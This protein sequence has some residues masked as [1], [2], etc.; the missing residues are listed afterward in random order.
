MKRLLMAVLMLAAALGVQAATFDGTEVPDN[1]QV[2]GVD[3]VLNGAGLRTKFVFDIYEG[4]LYLPQKANDTQAVLA[5]SG[6]DRILMHMIYAVSKSQFADAWND[7]F[8]DNN[9]KMSDSLKANVTQFIG[10]FG[11]SKK[12]DIV[13]IDYVPGTGTQVSWNGTLSGTIPGEE[14]HQAFLRVFFGSN[15]PTSRL[16]K[17]MLGK[18]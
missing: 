11:D 9:D 6:P 14:F 16:Q 7:G 8:G 2:G 4:A 15:P 13:T 5:H 17:G 18:S 3:L 1:A 12:G 10:Y